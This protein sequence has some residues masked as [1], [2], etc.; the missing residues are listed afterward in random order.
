M[1]LESGSRFGW[2][3]SDSWW[4]DSRG[5]GYCSP[6]DDNWYYR[7]IFHPNDAGYLGKAVGLVDEA[8]A[9]GVVSSR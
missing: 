8:L 2:T 5:H 1:V 4:R 6:P 7:L 3:A 9:L